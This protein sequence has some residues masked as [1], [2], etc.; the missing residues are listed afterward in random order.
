MNG[1]DGCYAKCPPPP[2]TPFTDDD[3]FFEADIDGAVVDK[4]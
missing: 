3:N 4:A 1:M 2:D